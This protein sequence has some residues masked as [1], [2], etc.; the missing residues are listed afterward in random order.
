[1]PAYGIFPLLTESKVAIICKIDYEKHTESWSLSVVSATA[2]A[3]PEWLNDM[4]H[5]DDRTGSTV[6]NAFRNSHAIGVLINDF[7]GRRT[8]N[9]PIKALSHE[10]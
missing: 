10:V 7:V 5:V 3:C 6:E 8:K 2:R 9:F 4:K 1:M